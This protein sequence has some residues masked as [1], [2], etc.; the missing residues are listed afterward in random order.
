MVMQSQTI[1]WLLPKNFL[2]LFDHF[3]GLALKEFMLFVS[4]LNNFYAGKEKAFIE[5]IE[6]LN[7]I[8]D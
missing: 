8:E 3:A 7:S 6:F 5:K 2:R 4:F 1:R